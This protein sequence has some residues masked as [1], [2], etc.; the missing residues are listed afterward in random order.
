[1]FNRKLIKTL[2]ATINSLENDLENEKQKNS[3]LIKDLVVMIQNQSKSRKKII[4]L[5]NNI[6]FLTNNIGS[7]KLKELVQRSNQN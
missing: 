4:D 6:E 3:Y 2:K 5:E 1:M 7:R